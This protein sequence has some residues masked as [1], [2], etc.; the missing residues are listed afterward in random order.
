MKSKDFLYIVKMS[1]PYP[2]EA[3]ATD[4]STHEIYTDYD[5][6]FAVAKRYKE[7]EDK[8]KEKRESN[9][10]WKSISLPPATIELFKIPMEKMDI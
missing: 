4:W 10:R 2:K 1:V 3:K 8:K 5:Q 7:R 9:S 6:A